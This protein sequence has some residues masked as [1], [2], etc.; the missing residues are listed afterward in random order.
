VSQ[1]TKTT[2]SHVF[3]IKKDLFL[4]STYNID[5][6]SLGY[7]YEINAERDSNLKIK[8]VTDID[9]RSINTTMRPLG[10]SFGPGLGNNTS[11]P[12]SGDWTRLGGSWKQNFEKDFA[13]LN[14]DLLKFQNQMKAGEICLDRLTP[15]KVEVKHPNAEACLALLAKEIDK[16]RFRATAKN[17]ALRLDDYLLQ[18][19]PV[20]HP[21]DVEYM[22]FKE[23]A[24]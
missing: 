10:L 17:L 3:D 14:Q 2:F 6:G 5:E 19:E 20:T 22:L 18:A 1:S 9:L 21:A 16:R 13:P 12:I 24:F 7:L 4:Q 15:L 8:T 23:S 11:F